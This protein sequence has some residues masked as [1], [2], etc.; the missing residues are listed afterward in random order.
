MDLKPFVT[1][2]ACGILL[3]QAGCAA[4]RPAP[5][6]L[7]GLSDPAAYVQA[8][9]TRPNCPGLSGI[10]R[11]AISTAGSSRS[12]KTVFACRYP[13]VLRIEVLGLFNQPGLY[14]SVQ[15]GRNMT[16][17]V[18]S[19][20]TWYTGPATPESMQHISGIR[21]DPFDIA[22]LVHGHPPG[23]DPATSAVSCAQD[24][25][26]YACTVRRGAITQR[27][28]INPLSKNITRSQLYEYGLLVYDIDFQRS[29]QQGASPVSESI[30][31]QYA[32]YGAT[33]EMRLQDVSCV[34]LTAAQLAL[35][36]PEGTP[37]LPIDALGTNN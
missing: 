11:I 30:R 22:R 24:G 33:I 1:A 7:P 32:R 27:L 26:S 35:K 16:L 37:V 25:D 23:P 17:Y 34:Q 29:R 5:E 9:L 3:I 28:L 12:Y 6:P 8:A 31:I 4:M 14:M 2:A 13:D 21:M 19:E 15:S 18:P 20:N 36:P 10:A